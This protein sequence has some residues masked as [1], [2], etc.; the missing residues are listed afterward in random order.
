MLSDAPVL[1]GSISDQYTDPNNLLYSMYLQKVR[2]NPQRSI[3][4]TAWETSDGG[5]KTKC[6]ASNHALANGQVINVIGTTNYNGEWTVEQVVANTSF[7]IA[8]P[9]VSNEGTKTVY[10][11]KEVV[12]IRVHERGKVTTANY[13][14]QV[15]GI[16]GEA[17]VDDEN[18]KNYTHARGLVGLDGFCAM[19]SGCGG[20]ITGAVGVMGSGYFESGTLTNWYA[21]YGANA[22]KTSATITNSYGLYLE[23]QTAGASQ[24]A[25]IYFGSTIELW[26]D[27]SVVSES[28]VSDRTLAITYRGVTYK[29][30]LKS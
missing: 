17:G 21:L 4:V 14:G 7:V 6:T 5:A 10:Y 29:L 3:T 11:G 27:V 8:T 20:T 12:G 1:Q 24:N 19:W 25:H 13:Y 2:T 23:R 18:T 15:I 26:G 28:V 9:Y 22:N 30:C 16:S